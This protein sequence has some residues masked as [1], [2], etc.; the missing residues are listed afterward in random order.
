MLTAHPTEVQRQ[1]ILACERE[2]ARLLVSPAQDATREHALRREILRLW[3]TAMLRLTRLTV[4]D[5]IE[6][7]LAFFRLTFLQQMPRLYADLERALASTFGLP[8]EP[9]L[10]PFMRVG[11]WIGGDRDGNPNV[12]AGVL[13]HA[14]GA[15]SRL[16][17]E[18]YLAELS[19]LSNELSL[20]ARLS[21]MPQA[22]LELAAA[23]AAPPGRALPH[24]PV[25]GSDAPRGHRHATGANATG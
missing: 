13:T 5:E 11:S 6:N 4:A 23:D 7:G 16:A 8:Q 9:L 15:Q 21:P 20:A 25:R 19:M 18:H 24:G 12:N 3:L 10:A 14:L 17:F 2:I 1:S 22:L